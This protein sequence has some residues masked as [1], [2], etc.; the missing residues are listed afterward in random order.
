MQKKRIWELDAFRGLCILGMVVVHL[1][2]DLM[3]TF[4]MPGLERSNLFSFVM[5]WGGVLFLLLSGIC[6]TLG[7]HP[8]RRGLI[9]LGAGLLCTIV[10]WAMAA[11]GLA[12]ASLIIYFGVLH[13]LGVCMLLWPIFRRFPNWLTAIIALILCI[14]GLYWRQN[15][16]LVSWWTMPFGAPPA[17]FVTSDY[18]PLFPNLGFFLFGSLLGKGLYKNKVSLF[19]RVNRRFFLI[20]FLTFCGRYSLLIYLLHQ[21]VITGILMLGEFL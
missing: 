11:L 14:V 17:D 5:L 16:P 15:T 3:N 12:D 1:L 18:F 20:R 2:F 9:V 6:V 10:T 7:H 4:S 19:P 21:P 13:C 8:I